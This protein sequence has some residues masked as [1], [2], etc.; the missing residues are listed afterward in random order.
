VSY[1]KTLYEVTRGTIEEKY[2][3]Q[4]VVTPS[5]QEELFFRASGY[6]SRVPYNGGDLVKKGE[7]L[8]ELQIEDLLNQL[9]QAEIDLEVA[10]ANLEENRVA[11]E[12]DVARAQHQVNLAE[13]NLEQVKAAGGGFGGNKTQ[14]AIAEEN[15]ALAELSLQQATERVFTYDEQAVK[16][17]QLVVDRLKAQ[18]AERQIVAPFDGILFRHSLKPGDAV[19]AF[20]PIITIGDPTALVIRTP[21]NQQLTGNLHQDT[22]SFMTLDNDQNE[23][24]TLQYLPN[25]VPTN[26]S[27][28]EEQD[29][30]Q[31]GG[32]FY[33][34]MV[35]QPDEELIPVGKPVE[36]MVVTGRNEN[37][38][39]LPRAVIREFGGLTFVIL[40]EDS[41][42]EG[43]KQRRVEVQIGLETSDR[44]EVIGDLQ[45]GDIILGP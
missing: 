9:Q 24:Y 37:A 44:V 22:E 19:E 28:E 15:L 34:D 32:Y 45:E 23:V 4:G 6:I 10:Q 38:L 33:F 7:I 42:A 21:R 14:V 13:L 26:L 17:T 35:D 20:D 40:S 31:A 18:I 3:L 25:F 2:E 12:F 30:V 36:V 5:I 41:G 29:P 8:A 39:I 16:R 11:Q 1:E 27:E 43:E